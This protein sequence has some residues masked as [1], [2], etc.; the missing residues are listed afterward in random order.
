MQNQ[1]GHFEGTKTTDRK[2]RR[3]KSGGVDV[4]KA[5]SGRID[6]SKAEVSLIEKRL[7]GVIY[8]PYSNSDRNLKGQ[9]SEMRLEDVVSWKLD[10]RVASINFDFAWV[11]RSGFE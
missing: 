4:S 9:S 2:R 3:A 1:K 8:A 6:V 7:V 10:A 11:G 5:K